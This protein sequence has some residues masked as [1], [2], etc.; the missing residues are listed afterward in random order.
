MFKPVKVD[1]KVTV[2]SSV[3]MVLLLFTSGYWYYDLKANPVN[4][5][6]SNY[7]QYIKQLE[8]ATGLFNTM[9]TIVLL[10]VLIIA[11]VIR[12]KK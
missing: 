11:F 2:S 5:W 12:S 6:S 10:S 1:V 7:D 4:T 3:A 8:I 9:I